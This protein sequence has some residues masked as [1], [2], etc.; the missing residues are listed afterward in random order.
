M[1]IP[2]CENVIGSD[3]DVSILYILALSSISVY[4]VI[5]SGWSS[6][7]QYAFLGAL[8]STAQMISYEVSIGLVI[9]CVILH[10]GSLSIINI[11]ESQTELWF[12]VPLFPV[13]ILFLISILAETNRPPFDLPEAE[14]EL[15]SGYNV[16]YGS[17]GF[18]LFFIGEYSNILLMSFLCSLFFL[19]G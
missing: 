14:A 19:G 2:F 13:F 15:V 7:S 5:L 17:L 12:F 11:V 8:R 9:L 4:A 16:E 18:A 1:V 10:T 6:N 3:L